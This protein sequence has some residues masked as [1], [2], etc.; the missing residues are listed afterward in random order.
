MIKKRGTLLVLGF[1]ILVLAIV[2]VPA[3]RLQRV[4]G[5][6]GGPVARSNGDVNG[7]DKINI[8]DA[9]FLLSYLFQDGQAPVA[10]AANVPDAIW[11][12]RIGQIV[13]VQAE[14]PLSLRA[15]AGAA[16]Y[17][18]PE[19][20]WLVV[21]DLTIT[22]KANGSKGVE[23]IERL[24]G[25]DNVKLGEFMFPDIAH[26]LSIEGFGSNSVVNDYSPRHFSS[27]VGTVFSP[28]STVVINYAGN[29][30]NPQSVSYNL[31]GYLT[32]RE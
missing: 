22:V 20:K 3:P 7:D 27:P 11:P 15:G 25:K 14:A 1:G 13:N 5:E 17:E 24:D 16:I 12:P 8:A 26:T 32:D 9:I 21:T 2:G 18:V 19:G 29:S 6:T 30:T 4:S 23:V 28:K 10:C 31:I